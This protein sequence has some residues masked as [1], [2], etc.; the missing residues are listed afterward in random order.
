MVSEGTQI[1][2]GLVEKSTDGG[3]DEL[4]AR[5]TSICRCD[6]FRI[7]FFGNSL[8]KGPQAHRVLYSAV[9]FVWFVKFTVTVM[10]VTCEK[11]RQA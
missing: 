6:C 7:S 3:V 9:F 5:F 1:L 11:Q 2:S 4:V 8:I 10:L